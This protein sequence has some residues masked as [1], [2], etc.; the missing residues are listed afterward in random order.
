MLFYSGSS[1]KK[2]K[3]LTLIKDTFYTTSFYFQKLINLLK[4]LDRRSIIIFLGL[5]CLTIA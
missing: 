1:E 5:V 4:T 3:E 2:K